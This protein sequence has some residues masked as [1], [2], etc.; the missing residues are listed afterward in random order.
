MTNL[1]TL[2]VTFNYEGIERPKTTAIVKNANGDVIATASVK[3][4]REDKPNKIVGRFQAFRKAMNQA[5]LR[6]TA[7][8]QQRTEA[9]NAFKT[10]CKVPSFLIQQ[11]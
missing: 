5:A 9:W 1:G 7:T 6:N 8:K 3:K 10:E 2:R 4:S 11:Q